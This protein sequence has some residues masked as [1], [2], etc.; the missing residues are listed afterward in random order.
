MKIW[1]THRHTLLHYHRCLAKIQEKVITSHLIMKHDPQATHHHL[2]H[3]HLH[4]TITKHHT[5]T[6][7]IQISHL[8]YQSHSY[9][10]QQLAR[11]P[12]LQ[13]DHYM[14]PNAM[15]SN[16]SIDIIQHHIPHI[17]IY[18]YTH[19]YT[20]SSHSHHDTHS[21]YTAAT[22]LPLSLDWTGTQD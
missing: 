21:S 20:H 18:I 1:I 14:Q 6:H 12:P 22:I 15:Q 4:T 8:P 5:D 13:H 2:L 3:S 7:T 17:H 16:H 9:S 10:P 19:Y 11:H